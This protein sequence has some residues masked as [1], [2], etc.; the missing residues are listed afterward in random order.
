M[1]NQ[2]S[3]N[4]GGF[5]NSRGRGG[6]GY[7]GGDRGRG[8]GRGSFR[9]RGRGRGGPSHNAIPPPE[10]VDFVGDFASTW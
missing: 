6:R 4:R 5:G 1:P 3:P 2:H 7:R 8:R 10:D 9:G